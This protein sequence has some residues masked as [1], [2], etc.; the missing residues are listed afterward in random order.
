MSNT[1]LGRKITELRKRR[2]IS[3]RAFAKE[4]ELSASLLS[5]IERGLSNPSLNTLRMI[6]DGLVIPLYTLFVDDISHESLIL[7]KEDRKKVYRESAQ[8][9]VFDLLSPDYMKS[10]IDI[11]WAILNPL[12]ETTSG[13][14]AHN[15]EEFAIIMK[16][17]AIVV[18]E[19]DE[20]PLYE[21]DTVR[22]LPRMKHKFRNDTEEKVEILYILTS[23]TL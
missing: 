7:R 6:A 2:G 13:H 8:H 15:R 17:Q 5:Q 19:D 11:L 20:Y 16:G 12:A 4:I 21:G 3:I 9:I 10:N 18:I 14:M 22:L 23:S 1:I